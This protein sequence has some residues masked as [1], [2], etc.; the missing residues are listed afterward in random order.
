MRQAARAILG[1]QRA[2]RAVR[3]RPC[4]LPVPVQG[5]VTVGAD[6]PIFALRIRGAGLF[7]GAIE[8]KFCE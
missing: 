4:G 7:L 8:A 1:R 6:Q 2:V 3:W 5:A